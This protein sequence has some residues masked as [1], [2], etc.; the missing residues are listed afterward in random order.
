MQRRFWW[1]TLLLHYTFTKSKDFRVIPCS[2]VNV[3]MPFSSNY[4]YYCCYCSIHTS[5]FVSSSSSSTSYF[6][7]WLLNSLQQSLHT[8]VTTK[9][10]LIG[11]GILRPAGNALD[12][13]SARWL[14]EKSSICITRLRFD[15]DR[16]CRLSWTLQGRACA[17][18]YAGHFLHNFGNFGQS[19]DSHENRLT[20][21]AWEWC[22]LES[23]PTH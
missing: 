5:L 6:L 20:L 18:H 7:L 3:K 19:M 22:R 13:S 16:L 17:N 4:H 11:S 23:P 1:Q 9:R 2:S 15:L 21:K 8:F 14:W 12:W 10:K